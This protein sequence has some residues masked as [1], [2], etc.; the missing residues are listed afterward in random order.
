MAKTNILDTGDCWGTLG[1]YY[2]VD[3]INYNDNTMK[4]LSCILFVSILVSC[5][6]PL[7]VEYQDSKV[8]SLEAAF[9]D[10]KEIQ[11]IWDSLREYKLI[12]LEKFI[13]RNK[14]D[15]RKWDSIQWYHFKNRTDSMQG[16]YYKALDFFGQKLD[17]ARADWDTRDTIIIVI[18]TDTAIINP[19]KIYDNVIIQGEDIDTFDIPKGFSDSTFQELLLRLINKN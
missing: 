7:I 11:A 16:V 4:K 18:Q 15:V 8:D 5:T 14:Q 6:Q 2:C 13:E 19:V 12:E 1:N 9:N 17:S 3:S 10:Y